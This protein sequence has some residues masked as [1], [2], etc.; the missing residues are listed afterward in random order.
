MLAQ[1]YSTRVEFL[2]CPVA[3]GDSELHEDNSFHL[4]RIELVIID[5][6]LMFLLIP[7][8]TFETVFV[9]I[10]TISTSFVA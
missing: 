2:A 9:E 7:K 3:R 1:I 6:S 10:S 4:L 8:W 5:T